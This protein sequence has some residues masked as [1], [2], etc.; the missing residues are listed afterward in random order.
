MAICGENKR[1]NFP[2]LTPNSQAIWPIDLL[3][4]A[5]KSLL[6]AGFHSHA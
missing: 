4:L 5:K 1:P 6:E 3:F 2:D